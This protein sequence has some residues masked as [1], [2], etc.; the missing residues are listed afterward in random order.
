[1]NEYANRLLAENERKKRNAPL[2]K[3][4]AAGATVP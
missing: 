3:G 2:P 1:M 4:A